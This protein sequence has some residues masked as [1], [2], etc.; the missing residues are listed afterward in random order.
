MIVGAPESGTNV[1]LLSVVSFGEGFHNNHH[2][3]PVSARMGLRWYE[4]GLGYGVIRLLAA[5]G[6]AQ[7]GIAR[8]PRERHTRP[9]SFG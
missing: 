7:G 6:L 2:R 4:L 9:S 8:K 3:Y 5:L 1:W